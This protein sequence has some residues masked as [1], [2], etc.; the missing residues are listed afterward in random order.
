MKSYKIKF[1]YADWCGYCRMF[2]PDW[3]KFKEYIKNNN[4]VDNNNSSVSIKVEE[5]N[6][7]NKMEMSKEKVRGFPTIIIY[8]DNNRIVYDDKRDFETL[9]K[10]FNITHSKLNQSGGNNYYN[11]YMKYKTKYLNSK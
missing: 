7:N 1:F 9:L 11:K 10:F 8:N 4:L 5:Y 3:N 6:D 2:K